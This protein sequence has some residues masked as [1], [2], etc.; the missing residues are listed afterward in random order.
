MT[1]WLLCVLLLVATAGASTA[2]AVEAGVPKSKQT[3]EAGLVPYVPTPHAVVKAML[4]MADV[5]TTDVVFDLGCGDGRIVVEA[6]KRGARAYGVDIDPAR[7]KEANA[8]AKKE[9][10]EDKVTIMLGDVFRTDFSSATVVTMYLLPEY[11]RRLRNKLARVLPV[12][13]RV[14]SHAFDMPGWE[15]EETRK[16]DVPDSYSHTVYFW[17]IT[18]DKK[19]QAREARQA[20]QK[21]AAGRE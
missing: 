20:R 4:D 15:A 3:E 10:V 12:G 18:P 6:A 16:V 21:A 14:V 19:K 17:K 11:N 13:A 8:L 2:W 9:G 1:G 7:V 5:K